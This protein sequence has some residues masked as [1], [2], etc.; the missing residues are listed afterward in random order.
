MRGPERSG[1]H[2]FKRPRRFSAR[3]SGSTIL[4]PG[5]KEVSFVKS[6]IEGADL[7]ALRGAAELL[8]KHRPLVVCEINPW[9]LE[10]Y[11]VS[12]NDL[13]SFFSGLEYQLYRYENR[14]LLV[15]SAGDVEEDNWVFVHP[16]RLDRVRDLLL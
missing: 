1:T 10:G 14:H 4:L 11:G 8:R 2:V 6:D 16:S 7:Y 15:K 12:V 9:F 3:S 13:V 5:L